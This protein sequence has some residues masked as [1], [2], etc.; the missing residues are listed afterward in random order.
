M[1]IRVDKW[2]TQTEEGLRESSLSV[3]TWAQIISE[4]LVNHSLSRPQGFE[5]SPGSAGLR[6]S[7]ATYRQQRCGPR[8]IWRKVATFSTWCG[9]YKANQSDVNCSAISKKYCDSTEH[10]KTRS[11]SLLWMTKAR[12][13]LWLSLSLFF[14]FL[15]R[16]KDLGFIVIKQTESFF[17]PKLFCLLLI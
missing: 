6:A 17:C 1:L 8:I 15:L 11:T 12:K 2:N 14:F 7:T 9:S 4:P 3:A 16:A 10:F 5:R 13:I